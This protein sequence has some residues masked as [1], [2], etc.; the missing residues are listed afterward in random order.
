MKNSDQAPRLRG[1]PRSFDRNA[2]LAVA[3]E[4]FWRLGYE[5]ASIADLTAAMAITP[6]S[7]Y[8]AFGSKAELYREA[9]GLYRA[10]S[11]ASLAKTLDEEPTVSA[12]FERVLKQRARTFAGRGHPAGCMISTAVLTCASENE[13]IADHLR[14]LRNGALAGFRAGLERENTERRVSRRHRCRR[15]RALS[16][17][18]D[19]G[20]GGAGARRR[21][22]GRP[23]MSRALRQRRSRAPARLS[24]L[25]LPDDIGGEIVRLVARELHVRHLRVRVHQEAR[26]RVGVEAG[27]SWRSWRTAA[28]CP[29]RAPGRARRRGR[30]RT[31]VSPASRRDRRR[32]RRRSRS[33]SARRAWRKRRR[34]AAAQEGRAGA[35][36]RRASSSAPPCRG[37]TAALAEDDANGRRCPGGPSA[38]RRSVPR[39]GGRTKRGGLAA[40][41]SHR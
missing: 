38:L 23:A 3:M 5:G 4:T 7:L 31:S 19:P 18:D 27:R 6:Q 24:L 11:G 15:A 37:S 36:R 22:R 34:R 30:P 20:D 14:E 13:P 39:S 41:P 32:R 28:R 26:D 12:A 2:A 33:R 9:L 17:R 29:A 21:E 40:A 35:W 25:A 16:R 1:R 8:A 10:T